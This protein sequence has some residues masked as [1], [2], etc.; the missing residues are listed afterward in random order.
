MDEKKPKA[1]ALRQAQGDPASAGS[2][3][4]KVLRAIELDGKLYFLNPNIG[5]TPPAKAKSACNGADIAVD[6]SGVIELT[7]QQASEMTLGQIE[8]IRETKTKAKKG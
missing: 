2:A 5:V 8:P 1:T 3:R 6:A 4:F 7:D